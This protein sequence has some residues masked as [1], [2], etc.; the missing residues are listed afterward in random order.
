[1]TQLPLL[2]SSDKPL[3][4]TDARCP[5]CQSEFK[6]GVAYLSA[7][8]LLLDKDRQNSIETDRLTAFLHIGFHGRE[9]DMSD[10]SDEILVDEL[11]GG[12]F[13]LQ[14]CSIKCMREWLL[15][16]LLEIESTIEK[17]GASS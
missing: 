2:S 16:L 9:S 15:K 4:P 1:M 13:D 7:G 8:A 5:V 11:H 17:S 10:S 14:W 6:N 3:Y 12:Q